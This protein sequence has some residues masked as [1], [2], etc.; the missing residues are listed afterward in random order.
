MK[1]GSRY[2]YSSPKEIERVNSP[3]IALI[4]KAHCSARRMETKNGRITDKTRR[5]GKEAKRRR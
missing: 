4:L 2:L 3:N 1:F 5:G